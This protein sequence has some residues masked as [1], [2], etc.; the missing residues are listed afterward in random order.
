[1]RCWMVCRQLL[2]Y[3]D[4]DLPQ[5]R[6][7]EIER[8][9][10]D[11]EACASKLAQLRSTV[12][13]V[14]SLDEVDAPTELTAKVLGAIRTE[15]CIEQPVPSVPWP[16]G[17]ILGVA[18]AVLSAMIVTVVLSM[19]L[20]AVAEWTTVLKPSAVAATHLGRLLLEAL[21]VG[22]GALVQAMGKPALGLL[23]VDIVLLAVL[24]T[25]GRHLLKGRGV[26]GMVAA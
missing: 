14:E 11:C 15:A 26:F 12:A 13:L 21:L 9:L 5:E 22:L 17:A 8:H 24:L 18:G 6:R 16:V 19:D 20:S 10:T 2:R 25:T 7:V 3:E 4:G 23:A 1:M